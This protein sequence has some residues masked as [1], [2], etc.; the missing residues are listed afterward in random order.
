[1]TCIKLAFIPL[2]L[3]MASCSGVEP[4]P[5]IDASTFCPSGARP[6][7]QSCTGDSLTTDCGG[8]GEQTWFACNGNMSCRLFRGGCVASDYDHFACDLDDPC[9]PSSGF[10]AA[11]LESHWAFHFHRSFGRSVENLDA[12]FVVSVDATAASGVTTSRVVCPSANAADGC[13][14]T[15]TPA[16][17]NDS[18]F[19]LTSSSRAVAFQNGYGVDGFVIDVE[20]DGAA[21]V[22]RVCHYMTTDY[23]YG[24]CPNA[25]SPSVHCASSGTLTW[26]GVGA[27][28]AVVVIDGESWTVEFQ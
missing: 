26:D 9:C 23:S 8:T 28:R 15:L 22:A 18:R 19:P 16:S 14:S 11:D 13:L 10:I 3:A 17:A 21:K 2:F 7:L 6:A 4:T 24:G 12:A 5:Q 25:Q 20:G 27:G 1:M